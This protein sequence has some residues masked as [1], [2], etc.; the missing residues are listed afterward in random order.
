[1]LVQYVIAYYQP[2]LS[3]PNEDHQPHHLAVL[4]LNL[5]LHDMKQ[6]LAKEGIVV[7]RE[8]IWQLCLK[9]SADLI[10]EF[11]R[12]LLRSGIT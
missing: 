3:R 1:M 11:R 2:W 8:S 9:I 12:C 6:I 7:A 10:C 4:K 5:S